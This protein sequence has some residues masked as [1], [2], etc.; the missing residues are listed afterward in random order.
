MQDNTVLMLTKVSTTRF[1]AFDRISRRDLAF[2][3]LNTYKNILDANTKPQRGK[4]IR[5]SL[6]MQI[7][8]KTTGYMPKLVNTDWRFALGFL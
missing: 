6:D 8:T 2:K 3:F 7:S 5:S 1:L 4:R